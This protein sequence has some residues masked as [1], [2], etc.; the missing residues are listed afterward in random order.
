MNKSLDKIM[1]ILIFLQLLIYSPRVLQ[2]RKR[3]D[4]FL[5][6]LFNGPNSTQSLIKQMK[7]EAYNL[8]SWARKTSKLEEIA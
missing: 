6:N 4:K 2:F 3:Y 1:I 8:L 7:N 5:N